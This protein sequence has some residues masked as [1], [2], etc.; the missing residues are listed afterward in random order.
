MWFRFTV[1]SVLIG[2]QIRYILKYFSTKYSFLISFWI[3]LRCNAM[4]FFN[5]LMANVSVLYPLKT[6]ENLWF[7]GVF[8]GY[9]MVTSARNGLMIQI[10]HL[11]LNFHFYEIVFL[12][13]FECFEFFLFNQLTTS[14]KKK[15]HCTTLKLDS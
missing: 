14:L 1:A 6:P 3:V 9:K 8:R 2:R 5:P 15:W 4:C 10:I 13:S 11:Q 12:Y 7:S